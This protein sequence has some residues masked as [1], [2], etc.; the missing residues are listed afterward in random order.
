MESE[1]PETSGNGAPQAGITR[2]S[3]LGN[4]ALLGVVGAA[5]GLFGGALDACS[6]SS[7]SA[8]PTLTIQSNL[9]DAP[10]VKALTQIVA[11]YNASSARTGKAVLSTVA[12]PTFVAQLPT[13]LTESAPPNVLLY[14]AGHASQQFGDKGY[15]LDVSSIW[16]GPLKNYSAAMKDLAT[17]SGGKQIFVPQ[18]YYWWGV[19][20]RKS[21]FQKW[22]VTP[23]TTWAQFLD[24]C[25]TIKKQ[26][27]NPLVTSAQSPQPWPFTGWFDYLDLRINGAQYHLDLLHGKHSFDSPQVKNVFTHLQSVMPYFDPASASYAYQDA[28]T[29]LVRGTAGMYLMGALITGVVPADIVDDIDFFKFPVIDPSVPDAEEAPTNGFMVPAKTSHPDQTK[30]LLAYLVSDEAQEIYANV[31]QTSSFPVSPTAKMTNMTPMEQ[32]GLAMLQKASTLTQFFNR[33]SDDALQTTNY[34]AMEAFWQSPNNVDSILSSWQA[35]AA[36]V[37]AQ[38]A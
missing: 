32:A 5:A 23:P 2:R 31:S 29:P 36:K 3:F 4:T 35:A 8:K 22:G 15:L 9:T 17:D 12:S 16:D 13:Y 24:V 21:M 30:N 28:A 37:F 38:E 33:D 10:S 14:W 18:S 20:Y 1:M 26:G 19:F 7:S 6:S 25:A 11:G 27:V 34:N